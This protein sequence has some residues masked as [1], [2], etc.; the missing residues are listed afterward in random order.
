M[1]NFSTNLYKELTKAFP[2]WINIK[3]DSG[4][5]LELDI[6]SSNKALIGGLAIQTTEDN[7]IW[8][9]NYHPY[10]GYSVDTIEE[11]IKVITGVLSDQILWVTSFKSE[12]WVET[13]LV[14]NINDLKTEKGARYQILSW[15][16]EFDNVADI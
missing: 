13:T 1:N 15:S 6:P 11:M 14:N 8:I 3:S 5:F 4:D 9:R 12:E 2:D 10:S 7:S 16:G